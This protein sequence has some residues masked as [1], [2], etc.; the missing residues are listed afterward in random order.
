[1]SRLVCKKCKSSIVAKDITPLGRHRNFI[2]P[3]CGTP[4][5]TYHQTYSFIGL[6][7]FLFL[8][9]VKTL[10]T[11]LTIGGLGWLQENSISLLIL[12]ILSSALAYSVYRNSKQ[13]VVAN[14]PVPK[15]WLIL[16]TVVAFALIRELFIITFGV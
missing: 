12:V 13:I 6:A 2:C 10:Y 16:S 4:I 9:L 1:M 14:I 3:K 5:N 15:G 7:G 8:W 11:Q